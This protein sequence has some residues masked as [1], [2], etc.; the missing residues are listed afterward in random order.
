M[1]RR[2]AKKKTNNEA[3]VE[4]NSTPPTQEEATQSFEDK[5]QQTN[6]NEKKTP[7]ESSQVKFVLPTC[8]TKVGTGG[9]RLKTLRSP[10]SAAPSINNL[11]RIALSG[12]SLDVNKKKKKKQKRIYNRNNINTELQ[13]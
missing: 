13:K 7:N 2:L 10:K 5:K 1:E 9:K 12:I 4:L 3:E 11:K 6:E 8:K